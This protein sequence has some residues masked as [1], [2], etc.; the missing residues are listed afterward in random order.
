VK[1]KVDVAQMPETDPNADPRLDP[2]S[3]EVAVAEEKPSGLRRGSQALRH[4]VTSLRHKLDMVN[5]NV[6]L[7]L[8]YVASR[9]SWTSSGS[10]CSVPACAS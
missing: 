5:R 6:P 9:C 8:I 3:I 1:A 10:R 4:Q 2:D 7:L